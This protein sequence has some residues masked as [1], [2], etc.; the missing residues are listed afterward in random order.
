MK[1]KDRHKNRVAK[2]RK[3]LIGKKFGKLTVIEDTGKRKSRRP[4]YKCLCDCGNYCEILGKYLLSG[5][6]KSC[7]C[8]N[9]GN[10]HNRDAVGEITKSFWTPILKQAVRRGIPFQITREYCWNL[11]LKQNRKC[12]LTGVSIEFSTN[13]RDERGKQTCSLDRIDSS[14]GYVEGNVQWV[15]KIINIMKNSLTQEDFIEWCGLVQDWMKNNPDKA[16]K[17]VGFGKEVIH[18]P[19]VKQD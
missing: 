5:D 4:I 12:N 8:F 15:H 7:G 2:N 16:K 10:A 13:I 14:K 6:T 18:A 11:Y 1:T 17:S 19:R 9:K 3:N